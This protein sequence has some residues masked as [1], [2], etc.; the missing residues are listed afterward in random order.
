MTTY[1]TK[2]EAQEKSENINKEKGLNISFPTFLGETVCFIY[3]L[4]K[5]W[6]IQNIETKKFY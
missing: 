1:T 3:G 2:L 6:Y 5:G 4:K